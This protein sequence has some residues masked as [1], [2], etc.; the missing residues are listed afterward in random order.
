MRGSFPSGGVIQVLF[1]G[2]RQTLVATRSE[3]IA[4]QSRVYV[5]APFRARTFASGLARAAFELMP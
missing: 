2:L 4:S 5:Y 3:G 1:L